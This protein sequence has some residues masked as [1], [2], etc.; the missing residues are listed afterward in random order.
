MISAVVLAAGYSSRMG[1]FKPLLPVGG[2][3]ALER[4]VCSIKAAGIKHI[5]VV[6]GSRRELLQPVIDQLNDSDT[7]VVEAY[8]PDFDDGMFTS[9]KTGLRKVDAVRG[10]GDGCLLMP[11]DC[12]L[13]SSAV[14]ETLC[15][16]LERDHDGIYRDFA[17]PVFEGKKGHPLYVPGCFI[18]EITGYDGPGGLK[19]VTDRHWDRMQR[20]P[21]SDEGCLL[22]MDTPEGY[23]EIEDFLA[24]GCVRESL[25]E[26]A[27]GRR[28]VL[29]RH[30]ETKQH[31]EKMFIGQYDVPLSDKGRE[32][33]EKTSQELRSMDLRPS[34]IY[35]SDLSRAVDSAKIVAGY[36]VH[37]KAEKQRVQ[38]E[39]VS[40][41]RPAKG[42]REINLGA[43]DGRPVQEIKEK[44]PE[45]YSRRGRDMFVFKTGN[46]SEN[47]YDMQ[48]R[49]VKTMRE[50]LLS[51]DSAGIVVVTHS[52]VIRALYNNI[53]GQRVDDPWESIPKGGYVVITT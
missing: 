28:I 35:C 53:R 49:A 29:V 7:E 2:V 40:G 32:Q 16:G 25:A 13:I 19:A 42:L 1:K 39:G 46:R 11:V 43:W 45:E 24:A 41:L 37:D 36:L 44:F 8:N 21:V 18:N 3:P 34:A 14:I 50:L 52:G 30:G 4:L 20:I 10:A 22:D 6:T 26:L 17:V 33:I 23:R 48:Y 9:I 47:F 27:S 31:D 15:S 5:A 38:D 12:P 51:D